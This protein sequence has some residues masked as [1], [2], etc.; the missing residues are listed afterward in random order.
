MTKRVHTSLKQPTETTIHD[1]RWG[2]WD[3]S[4]TT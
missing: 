4:G 1:I 3:K 2:D